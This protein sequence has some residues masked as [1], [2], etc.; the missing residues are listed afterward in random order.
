MITKTCRVCKIEKLLEDYNKKGLNRH[1][2]ECRECQREQ[3]RSYYKKNNEKQKKQINESK[4]IRID[5]N[6]LRYFNYLKTHP[7]IDCGELNPI[8]LEFD[9]KDNV[10][11]VST[12]GQLVW[13][14][15]SWDKIQ[16]EIEK[17]DVRCANCHRIRTSKQQDW[18]KNIL[19]IL[20][21]KECLIK[22]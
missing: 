8:V 19:P 11:K 7:C 6:R 14:G 9:H 12:V 4:K 20:G 3:A 18:Y 1:Q 15:Y 17:C 21:E 10:N 22:N 13:D 16:N 2:S 5:E